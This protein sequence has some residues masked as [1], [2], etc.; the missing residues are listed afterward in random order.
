VTADVSRKIWYLFLRVTK[1]MKSRIVLDAKV[2]GIPRG[3]IE[4]NDRLE[5]K[6]L[7]GRIEIDKSYAVSEDVVYPPDIDWF[8]CYFKLAVQQTLIKTIP[9]PKH[10]LVWAKPYRPLI[11]VCCRVVDGKNSHQLTRLS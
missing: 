1:R 10:Q 3:M 4:T 2:G 11:K 8:G 5:F 9:R 6:R 7:A